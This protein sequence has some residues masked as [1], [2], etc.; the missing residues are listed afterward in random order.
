MYDNG[1]GV[2]QDYVQAHKWF[3]VSTVSGDEEEILLAI[4]YMDAIEGEMTPDQI[5]EAQKLAK[6]WMEERQRKESP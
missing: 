4:Q 3:K 1:L 2:E 5:A 6:E